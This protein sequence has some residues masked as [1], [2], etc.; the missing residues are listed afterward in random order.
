MGMQRPAYTEPLNSNTNPLF[1]EV[2]LFWKSQGIK[3]QVGEV[4]ILL[5]QRCNSQDQS[6]DATNLSFNFNQVQILP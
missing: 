6:S 4:P 1:Q 3:I 5:S 2:T